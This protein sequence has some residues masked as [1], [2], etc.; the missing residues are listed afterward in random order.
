MNYST[1]FHPQWVAGF[2]DGEA[3]FQIDI[4]YRQKAA[5]GV[6]IHPRFSIG[7][8][9]RSQT[10]I[11]AFP[12]FFGC[13][14]VVHSKGM[15]FYKVNRLDDLIQSLIPFFQ[16]YPLHTAKQEDF[17]LFHALCLDLRKNTHSTQEGLV[18]MI[19]QAYSIPSARHARSLESVV[20]RIRTWKK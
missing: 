18:R 4:V 1:A 13:G 14:G 6:S 2:V 12:A 9:L 17:L 19:T 16:K 7:H 3:S 11:H 10:V 20:Y 15:A 8:H 5:F